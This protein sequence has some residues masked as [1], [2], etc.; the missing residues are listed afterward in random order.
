MHRPS[1]RGHGLVGA[2]RIAAWPNAFDPAR[3]R[4]NCTRAAPVV[5]GNAAAHT[6]DARPVHKRSAR[7]HGLVGADRIAD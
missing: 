2:D 4:C 3:S 7:G 6:P 1:A 5:A